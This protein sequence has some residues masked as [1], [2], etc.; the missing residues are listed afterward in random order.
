MAEDYLL[1]QLKLREWLS[2]LMENDRSRIRS[3]LN[4]THTEPHSDNGGLRWRC[5][6]CRLSVTLESDELSASLDGT[7]LLHHS[8][9]CTSTEAMRQSQKCIQLFTCC[10]YMDSETVQERVGEACARKF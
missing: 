10:S 2:F 6:S 8:I 1:L 9:P 5:T 7:P 3:L 4:R